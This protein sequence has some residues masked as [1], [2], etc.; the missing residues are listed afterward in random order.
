MNYQMIIKLYKI[1]MTISLKVEEHI[2]NFFFYFYFFPYLFKDSLLNFFPYIK[3][4]IEEKNK[5]SNMAS[6]RL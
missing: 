3:A 5:P 2:Y 6:C 4:R 1:K